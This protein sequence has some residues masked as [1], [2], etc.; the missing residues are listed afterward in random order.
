MTIAGMRLRSLTGFCLAALSLAAACGDDGNT[1]T[2]DS[3]PVTP[4][5]PP[6]STDIALEGLDGPVEVIVDDRGMPHIYATTVHDLMVVEG[7]LMAKDRFA[8]MEL[9]RRNVTGTL[10]QVAGAL[11]PT[12]VV[13][14]RQNRFL[15]FRRQGQAIYDS[16]PATSE[17]RLA[18]E[19]F[20][21]GVNQYIA[22][23][24]KNP[25]GYAPPKGN[26]ALT[27]LSISPNFG[28]PWSPADIFALARYQSW[29]LAYDAEGHIA[30]TEILQAALSE[31][32]PNAADA[33][34]AARAGLYMDLFSD[35]PARAS[36]T[37]D[38]APT[39]TRKKAV[40]AGP[41]VDPRSL[42]GAQAFFDAMNDNPLLKRSPHIGSNSWVVAGEKTASG[43]P[44][45]ANDPHLSLI[46]PP[47]W[48]YVH[49]NTAAM[50]GEKNLDVEGVAFAGLPGVVL[51]F[52]R[53]VAWSATTTGYDVTDVYNEQV[54]FRN[55]GTAQAPVW[56]PV[57]VRFRGA[58]V[59]LEVIEE[60]IFLQGEDQ[61]EIYK[62]YRVPHHGSIIPGSIVTP[63][64]GTTGS[65]L[66]IR[67]T[68][69]DVSDELAFFNGLQSA[70]SFAD[71]D[72]AQANFKVG[73]QN[74]SA[75]SATDGIRWSS[76]SRVPVRDA[77]ACTFT[78]NA[79]GIPSGTSPMFVLDGASGDFEWGADI[80]PGAIPKETNPERGYIATANQDNI[81][82]T[83]D[84]NPCNDAVYLGGEFDVGYRQAR[85]RE[86]LD[87]LGDNMT[88]AQMVE[89]QAETKSSSGE[90]MRT[91]VLA[92]I[93]AALATSI[94]DP[95]LAA[96]MTEL[97][98]TGRAAL[99][100][101][102]TRL[103]AWSLET[104]H[105]VGA[106]AAA[107]IADSVA[108]TVWNGILTRLASLTLDD[109]VQRIGYYPGSLAG[110]RSLEWMLNEAD[111]LAT[112]RTAYAGVAAYNDS[113]LWDHLGT[114][115]VVENRNERI[116]RAVAAAYTFLE[117]RLGADKNE[118]RWGRLHAVRFDQIVPSVSGVDEV[119]IPPGDSTQ[120]PLGF[121]RH[122][123]LGAVD[124][125]NYS[126]Y[127][128][129]NFTFGHGASQR[130]VVEMTPTGPVAVN[131]LPGGQSEA[132]DS[133]HHADEAEHWRVNEQPP[134]YFERADVEA[135][136][137]STLR[138]VPE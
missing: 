134:L 52:N 101:A 14:D 11:S 130:L 73:S 43:N 13:G 10:A 63:T 48:W 113:V 102:K 50:G 105:G 25:N 71:I 110:M 88:P 114:T 75:V 109:E 117:G 4:D 20:V 96:A 8:Q 34:V 9:I 45:L 79:Q 131:A 49:L 132:T 57:S 122:G 138:F 67:Y 5:A 116:A 6:A 42:A 70:T 55:D 44:I 103:T 118:W 119:S 69:D 84:G 107:E 136:Q 59:A 68:G 23:V 66:S 126:L 58:D 100:D 24:V 53:K 124:P 97:G 104:P 32:P 137:V 87:A 89:L 17:S 26:E 40:V 29:N 38:P 60:E 31:F 106:T 128:T 51:G 91:A 72:A 2:P 74:F 28:D 76:Q 81:G 90:G 46:S 35:L 7:Y 30:R 83:A 39:R 18:A 120:F 37:T 56:V 129:Q 85:I 127:N 82:V 133:P 62:I 135:H 61:P 16:L 19:A 121:P 123:D 65:A 98:P 12:I 41:R 15:G 99:M 78:Y 1:G 33:R 112:Y 54:T 125:G 36:F 77:R 111:S 94:T 3:P 115:A 64:S 21:A 93:D 108:T 80:T 92:A 27:A 95:V 22:K 86:G 47:V